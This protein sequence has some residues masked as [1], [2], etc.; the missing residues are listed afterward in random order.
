MNNVELSTNPV[1]ISLI[2]SKIRCV[3]FYLLWGAG[4]CNEVVYPG[5]GAAESLI[6]S[7]TLEK[8]RCA[9]A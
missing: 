3:K 1:C 5:S 4:C 6:E 2:N 8:T 7:T 9:M